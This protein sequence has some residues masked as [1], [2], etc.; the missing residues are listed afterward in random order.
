MGRVEV[1]VHSPK[2]FALVPQWNFSTTKDRRHPAEK[3]SQP[4]RNLCPFRCVLL[5]LDFM[6]NRPYGDRKR[7]PKSI[8]LPMAV[9]FSICGC[10]LPRAHRPLHIDGS[11]LCSA[12]LHDKCAGM[13]L[14]ETIKIC[15]KYCRHHLKRF[16]TFDLFRHMGGRRSLFIWTDSLQHR[17]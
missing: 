9:S 3:A 10:T 5:F 16:K 4:V 15:A 14:S 8:K 11:D 13:R 2:S 12:T 1:L 7:E 6:C 17:G